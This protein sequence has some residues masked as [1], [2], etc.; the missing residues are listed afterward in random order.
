MSK[1]KIRI[2]YKASQLEA[3]QTKQAP[4]DRKTSRG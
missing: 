2:D 1:L 3:K 4:K